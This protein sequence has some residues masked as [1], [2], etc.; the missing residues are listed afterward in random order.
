MIVTLVALPVQV[1]WTTASL[2]RLVTIWMAPLVFQHALI[3][4]MVITLLKHVRHARQTV[5]AVLTRV[6]ALNVMAGSCSKLVYVLVDAQQVST[7]M[8]Q[9][10]SAELVCQH[11]QIVLIS[12]NVATVRHSISCSL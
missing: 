9:I 8:L 10:K 11:A 12:I 7:W 6:H 2:V 3:L 1:Q 5:P 4:L